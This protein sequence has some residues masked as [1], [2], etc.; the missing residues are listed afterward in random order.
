MSTVQ[1]IE[2]AIPK[3]SKEDLL[4]F[5][6]WY[7]EFIEDQLEL[8]PEIVAALEESRSD[9]SNGNFTTRQP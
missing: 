2:N 1:E 7:E 9:I 4:E 8:K 5:H 3:L 6:A